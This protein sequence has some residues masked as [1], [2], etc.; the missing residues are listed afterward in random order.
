MRSWK[1]EYKIIGL[2]GM[3]GI[4]I[5]CLGWLFSSDAAPLPFENVLLH[6][7]IMKDHRIWIICL[8]CIIYGALLYP[9]FLLVTLEWEEV[10]EF[11]IYESGHP[12]NFMR[13]LSSRE[14][15][16]ERSIAT[17]SG[18]RELMNSGEYKRMRR[19]KGAV[20]REWNWQT[21]VLERAKSFR[22]GGTN[23]NIKKDSHGRENLNVR[24]EY[25][26]INVNYPE[27]P[28]THT[29]TE[30]LKLPEGL[31]TRFQYSQPHRVHPVHFPLHTS[32]PGQFHS[33][34]LK[35]HTPRE[36][37]TTYKGGGE[38]YLRNKTI[39]F[40]LGEKYQ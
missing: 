12:V 16:R 25:K 2:L 34:S 14:Y 11:P 39:H 19:E 35:D 8:L 21:K 6:V 15:N 9:I 18:M 7:P 29:I 36:S 13:R 24:E 40:Q 23:M 33:T 10:E 1:N 30:E 5:L 4:L 20:K 27:A 28:P 3:I 17:Q 37:S 31:T 38:Y 32:H 22:L 26:E